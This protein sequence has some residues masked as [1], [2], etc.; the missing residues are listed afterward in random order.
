MFQ[1]LITSSIKHKFVVGFLTISLIV[2]GLWSLATLPFDSTPDIT[3]NQVQVITQAPS[4]GA[5]EVEQYVTTP[6]EMALANIPRLQERRSISR[7]GLSV[8]TLI[9]DDQADIYWARSQVSQ[10][11]NDAVKELPKNTSTE[12]G[13]IA[14]ALGEI[15]HYTVRTKKGYE[16]K[17]SLTQLRTIQDWIVRK[18]LSGTPGVAEVSGWGGFVKQY[19]VAINTDRLNANGITVSEVF[20][21]LQRTTPIPVEAIL[22]KLKPIL[23]PCYWCGQD[24]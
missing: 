12:M 9:F 13:P 2:W 7:S 22:S 11:L 20:D 3:D 1:K 14:T 15:Y 16:N 4:L 8:I 5:Q 10:V 6:I 18:Q 23:H 19:E 24:F 17:Y 21:A